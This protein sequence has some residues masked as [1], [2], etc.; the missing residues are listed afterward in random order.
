MAKPSRSHSTR[1]VRSAEARVEEPSMLQWPQPPYYE[2]IDDGERPREEPASAQLRDGRKINGALTRFDPTVGVFEM[3]PE[4]GELMEVAPHDLLDLRLTRP[5]T[6]KRRR[7]VIDDANDPDAPPERQLFRVT[8]SNDQIVEGETLGFDT[9]TLGLFL[10]VDGNGEGVTRVFIPSDAIKRKQIGRRL[11][12]M[13]LSEQAV[14]PV[15]ISRAIERQSAVRNRKLGDYLTREQIISRSDLAAAIER[16]RQMPVMRLGEALVAMALISENQLDDALSRQKEQRGKPLGEILVDLGLITRE[17]LKRTLTQQLG[18][19]FVDLTRYEVEPTV[20]KLVPAAVAAEYNVLPLCIDGRA[21]VLAVENPLDPIPL[22]RI[23]FL[24][25]MP[26]APVMAAANE[27]REAVKLHYGLNTPT[28]KIEDLAAE[29]DNAVTTQEIDED[30]VRET[31]SVLVRLVNKMVIDASEAKAS[32]IHIESY[33]GRQPVRIRFRQDGILREYLTLPASYRAALISRVKIM[34]SLDISEKRRAQ[35]GKILFQNFGPAKLELRLATIPTNDGLEDAVLRVLPG[36][37]ATPMD[38]LGLR[39][40]VLASL[41]KVAERPYG[42]LL[43][44]GPTGS[45]K[46]TTLHSVLSHINTPDLKIWTAED[47]VEILQPG[48]RQVQVHAKIGWTFAA[49]M[50]SFLRADPDVIMIGEMRDEETARIAIEAS[51]TG[52][53]VLSTLHTNSAPESVVRLLDMGM[54][55]F[56]FA[57][58]MLGILAQRLVR[59]LCAKCKVLEP[60]H[61][62]GLHDLAAEYCTDTALSPDMVAAEWLQRHSGAPKLPRA[63]GCLACGNSGYS[64]RLGIHELLVNSPLIRPLIRRSAGADELRTAGIAE[65]MRTLRQDGIEKC[66]DGLTDIHE[67]RGACA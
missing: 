52:H 47:P 33:P 1:P 29:L 63:P 25:G 32:D 50:R 18:I 58:S 19:P 7:S 3:R 21:L 22:D 8:L 42:I 2:T 15:Q 11:G 16:Q 20:L 9:H 34:A 39:P 31:D 62:Q 55:P 60:L 48:L 14:T 36:G 38:Q 30:Q 27:L 13:L 44:C 5:V 10:Y 6:L 43:V 46:T 28:V 40:P 12:D 24:S 26:I 45:G 54:Q 59:R 65:G 41:E 49:A 23:R 17:D 53:L 35:D 51:L 67:V 37:G 4:G 66:L 56:N 57:D 61:K 64:G